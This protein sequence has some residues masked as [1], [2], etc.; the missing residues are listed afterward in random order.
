[1]TLAVIDLTSGPG[2]DDLLRAVANADKDLSITFETPAGP[3]AAA[4]EQIEEHGTDGLDF[5]VWGRLAS[6]ELRGAFFTAN[7]NCGSRTGRLALKTAA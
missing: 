2:K 3:M 6:T 5:T 1:M 7:Y 4:V